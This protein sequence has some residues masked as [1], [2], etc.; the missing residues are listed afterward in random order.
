MEMFYVPV[1]HLIL[2]HANVQNNFQHANKT[3]TNHINDN[4]IKFQVSLHFWGIWPPVYHL[5]E[6]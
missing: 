3:K 2:R 5:T 1:T 4:H 6:K